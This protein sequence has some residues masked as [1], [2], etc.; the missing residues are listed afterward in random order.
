MQIVLPVCTCCAA[1]ASDVLARLDLSCS[2]CLDPVPVAPLCAAAL[3]NELPARAASHRFDC[4]IP[5]VPVCTSLPVCPI[6][7]FCLYLTRMTLGSAWQLLWWRSYWAHTA[8]LAGCAAFSAWMGAS[9]Q[10]EIFAHRYLPRL[11]IQPQ[12]DKKKTA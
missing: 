1:I 12:P 11:G 6:V 9:Y 3:V 10:F 2:V 7:R 5:S 8:W 4:S